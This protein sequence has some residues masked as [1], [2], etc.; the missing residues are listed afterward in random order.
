LVD[1]ST[2]PLYGDAG[3]KSMA[4]TG[5]FLAWQSTRRPWG[6]RQGVIVRSSCVFICLCF[7]ARLP[8][9][10]F[11]TSVG[12]DACLV[13]LPHIKGWSPFLLYPVL[14]WF[15]RVWFRYILSRLSFCKKMYLAQ[16]SE[17]PAPLL[18]RHTF[19]Y[20]R[21]PAV[22]PSMVQL[23]ISSLFVR[24][25]C[26]MCC[27]KIKTLFIENRLI[28]SQLQGDSWFH[29]RFS[30]RE[31]CTETAAVLHTAPRPLAKGG[32]R[33][34]NEGLLYA[35]YFY[36][37]FFVSRRADRYTSSHPIH[38]D[39][40]HPPST[41]TLTT[42]VVTG[43]WPRPSPFRRASAWWA[44]H[45]SKKEGRRTTHRKQLL[46]GMECKGNM[47][48]QAQDRWKVATWF[49]AARFWNGPNWVVFGLPSSYI[50]RSSR[51][52][53]E[54]CRLR[55]TQ[56]KSWRLKWENGWLPWSHRS[57]SWGGPEHR[58]QR[59]DNNSLYFRGEKTETPQ[60]MKREGYTH[61]ETNPV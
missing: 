56:N 22:G 37:T 30:G 58:P 36:R 3:S 38:E 31:P 10:G 8:L 18:K 19:V 39:N 52:Y 6:L 13:L 32:V 55:Q 15:A 25:D 28:V 43:T 2:P 7:A 35:T 29:G 47:N 51:F 45:T 11:Q 5:L 23:K 53:P 33:W 46:Y 60:A 1:V 41:L 48:A 61:A 49:R 59:A 16:D 54:L 14:W 9:L 21:G 12:L 42:H 40:A 4:T 44:L 24:G 26:T 27:D 50:L 20:G 34:V 57:E 17:V